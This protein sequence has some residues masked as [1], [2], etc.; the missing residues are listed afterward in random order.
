MVADRSLRLR[1]V[2]PRPPAR[3]R[4]RPEQE[5]P[6]R[7]PGFDRRGIARGRRG[8]PEDARPSPHPRRR[9]P[10]GPGYREPRTDRPHVAAGAPRG[11]CR[12]LRPE[13]VDAGVPRGRTS[14]GDAAERGSPGF[15]AKRSGCVGGDRDRAL[16]R[17]TGTAP[18]GG[19]RVRQDPGGN[20]G[21][22][23]SRPLRATATRGGGTGR[24]APDLHH[25]PATP[26]LRGLPR[27]GRGFEAPRMGEGAG[28]FRG[29]GLRGVRP[30]VAG[31]HRV[32]LRY[33]GQDAAGPHP[34]PSPDV[35]RQSAEAGDRGR[36]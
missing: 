25:H 30:S 11:G 24:G 13:P 19:G 26:L 5:G 21:R 7:R 34:A 18:P 15:V 28:A 14:E 23:R 33:P 36:D 17:G 31:A 6:K 1:K 9:L 8:R 35:L 10:A 32:G 22:R 27:G 2:L 16:P 4:L 12:D 29:R 20:P 3:C